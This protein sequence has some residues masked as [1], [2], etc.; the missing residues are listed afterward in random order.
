MRRGDAKHRRVTHGADLGQE[1]KEAHEL[2][3][4][5]FPREAAYRQAERKPAFARNYCRGVRSSES[6]FLSSTGIGSDATAC[7]TKT[8]SVSSK[9]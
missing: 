9:R 6:F 7:L 4:C 2:G 1:S 5:A 3:S 8:R